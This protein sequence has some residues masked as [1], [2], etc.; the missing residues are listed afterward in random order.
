MGVAIVILSSEAQEVIR[1]C[2]RVLV[3]YHGQICG[4]LQEEAINEH[5]IMQLATSGSMEE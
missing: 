5:S 3:M 2:D 1:I 4:E